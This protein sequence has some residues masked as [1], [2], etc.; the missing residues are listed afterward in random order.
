MAKQPEPPPELTGDHIESVLDGR[1]DFD[2]ELFAV[3]TLAGRGWIQH[4]GGVYNDPFL[5][6]RRQ[7][8]VRARKRFRDRYHVS[9]AVECK[10]L[11]PDLPLVVSRVP[12]PPN[13]ARHDVVKSW[14]ERG[15]IGFSV[16]PSE[17]GHI[18]LYGVGQMVGKS[19]TRIGWDQ[20]GKT[21]ILSEGDL[22]DRW[23]QALSSAVELINLAAAPVELHRT[24]YTFVMPILLI[25]DRALWVV[26]YTEDG[27]RSRPEPTDEA[28]YFA[29]FDH[30][31]P[32]RQLIY[33]M[34]HLHIYTR[35]GF[36]AML[37]NYDSPT[38]LMRDRTFGFILRQQEQ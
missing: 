27:A 31:L 9:L 15:D 37:N 28:L 16:E 3:R 33:H 30:V 11:S 8:D 22:Y 20:R 5:G 38:G 17:P 2:L 12:R 14:H 10:S 18:G 25:N 4:H 7:Y 24:V 35:T 26:D 32:A 36:A 6:K 23:T 13:D 21:L 34:S 29:D 19:L 1:D